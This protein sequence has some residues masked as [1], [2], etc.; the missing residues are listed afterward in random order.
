MS[1]RKKG[2]KGPDKVKDL[3]P[4]KRTSTKDEDVKGGYEKS[5]Q[6]ATLSNILSA[7]STTDAGIISNMK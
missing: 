3:E 6:L 2:R 7:Q 5:T 1:S 4:R